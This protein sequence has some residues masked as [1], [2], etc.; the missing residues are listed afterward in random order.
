MTRTVFMGREGCP[1]CGR[2]FTYRGKGASR[3][4]RRHLEKC[5]ARL[6]VIQEPKKGQNGT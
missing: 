5:P 2:S 4:I 3:R 1:W 6:R